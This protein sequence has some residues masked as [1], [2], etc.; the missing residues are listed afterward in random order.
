[1]YKRIILLAEIVGAR[2]RKPIEAFNNIE[3][4]SLL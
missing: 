1:M 4:K 3:A 2:R